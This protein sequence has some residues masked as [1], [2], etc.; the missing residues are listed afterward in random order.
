MC[1]LNLF[2]ITIMPAPLWTLA[3]TTLQ[4]PT[5]QLNG[6]G[7]EV[8]YSIQTKEEREGRKRDGDDALVA[9]CG[10]KWET[11][12]KKKR[13]GLMH[14]SWHQRPSG[15]HPP[16][17]LLHILAILSFYRRLAQRLMWQGSI[18]LGMLYFRCCSLH[19]GTGAQRPNG[20]SVFVVDPWGS[21]SP[22]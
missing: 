19:R 9:K 6:S 17:A 14:Q 2:S 21:E 12:K 15:R 22:A 11:K 13:S 1:S 4:P 8:V 16:C 3:V 5:P 20:V 18:H 10:E 7:I